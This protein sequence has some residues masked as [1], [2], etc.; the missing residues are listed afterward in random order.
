MAI[1]VSAQGKEFNF[2]DGTTNDQISESVDSF[3]KPKAE[4]QNANIPNNNQTSPA[5]DI[6]HKY[7][8]KHEIRPNHLKNGCG[9]PKERSAMKMICDYVLNCRGLQIWHAHA[10][11]WDFEIIWQSHYK[12]GK[13]QVKVRT[14]DKMC[15]KVNRKHTNGKAFMI[16]DKES[17]YVNICCVSRICRN[18]V[19]VP[20]LMSDQI[21]CLWPHTPAGLD[22]IERKQQEFAEHAKKKRDASREKHNN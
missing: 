16:I 2:P 1:T 4:V 8:S 5:A 15:P 20:P 7:T 12:T 6:K 21:L 19:A 14:K 22:T 13:P 9:S 3:F 10:K 11:N 17:G 18:F